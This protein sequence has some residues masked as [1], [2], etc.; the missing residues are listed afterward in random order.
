M[1]KV[2]IKINILTNFTI[3]IL[4]VVSLLLS[5]QYYSNYQLATNAVDKNFQQTSK[6]II[7]FIKRSEKKT[8]NLL[9]LLAINP[10]LKSEL[11]IDKHPALKY[12][13]PILKNHPNAKSIYIGY[14]DDNLYQLIN[15]DNNQ[16]LRKKYNLTEKSTWAVVTTIKQ[17]KQ[18]V[19]LDKNLKTLLTISEMSLFKPTSR[20]WY[21]QALKSN[22]TITTKTYKY[23]ASND[24]GISFAKKIPNTQTV[25]SIDITH[26]NLSI[27]LKSKNFDK[28]SF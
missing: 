23:I 28:D 25:I 8:K 10:E 24:Y 1:P 20:I 4:V 5:L 16:Q 27:F 7:S 9:G 22:K 11:T 2:S 19:F 15:L 13:V 26:Q 18:I 12:F 17:Q 14:S 6:S 21:T 3:L